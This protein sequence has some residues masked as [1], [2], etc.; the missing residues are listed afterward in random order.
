ML[1]QMSY[2]PGFIEWIEKENERILIESSLTQIQKCEIAVKNAHEA[3][4]A[5]DFKDDEKRIVYMS[6]HS[7]LVKVLY[8]VKIV[9][10]IKD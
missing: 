9:E 6:A 1:N 7:D 10:P 4:K 3:W 8:P 5:T 2:I